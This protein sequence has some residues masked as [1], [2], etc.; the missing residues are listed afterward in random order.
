MSENG[1]KPLSKLDVKLVPLEAAHLEEVMAI[2]RE[3]FSVPW[4]IE[5]FE[6]LL[7]NRDAI[8]YAAVHE[9]RVIGYSC[10]WMVIE[11]AELG[12][13]AVTGRYQGRSV[14]RTMLD[15]TLA[16]CRKRGVEALFLEV[17][18]SNV[19][20]VDLYER[21]G[22]TRIGLRRGYYSQPVED[23]LIMKLDLRKAR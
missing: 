1:V 6:K 8:C 12:N 16:V 7:V 19:R 17:R 21:Y 5:D 15:A 10:C 22:F 3:V 18:C 2:E 4:R 23:A 9:G 14:G 20:A 13:L 11:T